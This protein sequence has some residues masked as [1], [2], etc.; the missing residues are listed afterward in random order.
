MSILFINAKLKAEIRSENVFHIF[1]SGTQV[2][3]MA[4]LC[5]ETICNN[6]GKFKKNTEGKIADLL[7]G[8]KE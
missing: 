8:K 6:K 7:S 4:V 5:Q 2:T 3:I 1:L